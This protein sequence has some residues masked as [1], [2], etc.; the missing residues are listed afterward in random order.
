MHVKYTLLLVVV[1]VIQNNIEYYLW[2]VII[3]QLYIFPHGEVKRKK[4]KR[5]VEIGPVFLEMYR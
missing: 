3:R 5:L 4:L 2:L 1:L